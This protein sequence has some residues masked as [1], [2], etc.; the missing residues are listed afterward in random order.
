MVTTGVIAA[1]TIPLLNKIDVWGF[2][3]LD[4]DGVLR[5]WFVNLL[6]DLHSSSSQK[7]T[8]VSGAITLKVKLFRHN[9]ETST[10]SQPLKRLLTYSN[11]S[12]NGTVLDAAALSPEQITE[13]ISMREGIVE[14]QRTIDEKILFANINGLDVPKA[15][16]FNPPQDVIPVGEI[17]NAEASRLAHNGVLPPGPVKNTVAARSCVPAYCSGQNY[18]CVIYV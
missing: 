18:Q 14:A 11:R 3:N 5:S 10:P 6:L 4:V 9:S 13:F 16:L 7:Y 17:A 2:V 1:T 12:S 15:Q 8:H